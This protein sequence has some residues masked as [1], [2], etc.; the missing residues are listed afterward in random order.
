MAKN[1]TILDRKVVRKAG[2]FGVKVSGMKIFTVDVISR[3]IRKVLL[4][5]KH[6]LSLCKCDELSE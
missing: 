5:G 2:N 4:P 6:T 3:L 1:V